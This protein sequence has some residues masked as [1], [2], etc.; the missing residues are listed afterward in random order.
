[1]KEKINKIHEYLKNLSTI[2]FILIMELLIFF[3][4]IPFLLLYHI[5]EVPKAY[6]DD[7]IE[8]AFIALA[9]IPA[10]KLTGI[11]LAVITLAESKLIDIG[12]AVIFLLL[13]PFFNTLVFQHGIIRFLSSRKFFEN[14]EVWI[15]VI[16]AILFCIC[17]YFSFLVFVYYFLAGL[18]LAYAYMDYMEKDFSAFGVVFGIYC[19]KN[20]VLMLVMWGMA[21][22]S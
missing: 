1:M 16:S 3:L 11:V 19:I 2:K 18:V 20:V 17:H 12:L 21:L 22:C 14:K 13:V 5:L 15:G 7:S 10:P 6:M 9:T 4:V 8:T